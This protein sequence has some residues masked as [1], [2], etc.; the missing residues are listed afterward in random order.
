MYIT[1]Y[2]ESTGSHYRKIAGDEKPG[3]VISFE[4]NGNF[5]DFY[6]NLAMLKSPSFGTEFL[7]LCPY[8]YLAHYDKSNQSQRKKAL[9]MA[10]LS[11]ELCR[12]SVGLEDP[13]MIKEVLAEALAKLDLNHR[14]DGMQR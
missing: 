11:P 12:L 10:G 13:E 2:Q 5:K 14:Y 8:I 3:C 7:S 6:N 4:I 9:K 1:A